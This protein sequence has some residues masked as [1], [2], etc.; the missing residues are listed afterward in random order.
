MRV[1]LI[2]A[3]L[4]LGLVDAARRRV[5][6]TTL[7][8]MTTTMTTPTSF[9]DRQLVFAGQPEGQCQRCQDREGLEP[10]AGGF[11][12]FANVTKCVTLTL[13]RQEHKDV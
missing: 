11:C 2:L 4:L 9:V 8:A 1:A 3:V 12:A 10:F 13:T 5:R 7:T 6:S